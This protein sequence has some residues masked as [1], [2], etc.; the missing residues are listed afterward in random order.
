MTTSTSSLNFKSGKKY[1]PNRSRADLAAREKE[2]EERVRRLREQ[3]EDDRRRKL[4]ELKQHAL[5]AQKFREQ[6][7]LE[8]RRHIESLRMKDM[9]RRQQVE[10]RRKEIEKSE[11]DRKEAIIQKNRER[12]S[13]LENQRRSSRSNIDFAFGSSAPR[14]MEPRVDSASGYWGTRSTSGQTMFDRSSASMDRETGQAADLRSKRTASAHGLNM[15]TEGDTDGILS[16]GAGATAHRRRTDLV[17]TI[18]MS[19]SDRSGAMTPGS[20]HRSPVNTP[21]ADRMK[22]ARSVTSDSVGAGGDNDDARSVSSVTSSGAGARTPSR[23]T[24]SQV[25]AENAARKAKASTPK[26]SST[27]KSSLMNVSNG[28]KEVKRSSASKTPSPA[29]SQDNIETGDIKRRQSTPDII[30]DNNRKNVDNGEA[31]DEDNNVN[32]DDADKPIDNENNENGEASEQKK[33][34]TSE[35]E[36]KAR[37]AEK[38]TQMKE[39]KEREAE[40]EKLRLEEEARQ[41]AER[42]RQEEEEEKRLIALEEEARKAEEERIRKAIEEKEAEDRKKKEEEERLRAEKEEMERKVKAEAERREAELQEKLKKEEEERLARKK[43]IEEIMAR[44]RNKG[45]ATPKKEEKEGTEDGSGTS[46]PP[47]LDTNVDPTKPDL[48]GDINDKVEEN[49]AKNLAQSNGTT[50][51]PPP[52]QQEPES[53]DIEKGALDSI[54]SKSDENENSSPLITVENGDA[55]VKKLNGLVEGS[56]FDQILDLGTVPDSNKTQSV[57]SGLPPPLMAF[58]ESIQQQNNNP[59]DLLS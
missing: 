58:E 8:R 14:M 42:M 53:Q 23:K 27:P 56:S 10:E 40:L 19:R 39:Q 22:R 21:K 17:P 24:P 55:P 44:T 35:E 57:S 48:L 25:K 18:V 52:S 2:R 47:S 32:K 59:T 28:G 37:I 16:P 51:T 30:K 5:Q 11:L 54:S 33:I 43:R 12:D 13:R 34:I 41:E 31:K 15:S 49:N 36:A 38:R 45:A 26:L 46:Q 50:P 1:I 9:D 20:R 3:Q 6:Q 4:E 29:L 7:E